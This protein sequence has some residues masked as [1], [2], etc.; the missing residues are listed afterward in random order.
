M[1]QENIVKNKIIIICGP[2]ASSKTALAVECAKRLN[3][4]VISADS[5]YVYK[6][7]NVG[8]AK[9]T[10]DEMQGVVHHLIDVIDAD[11]T[12]SVG[13]YK[14]LAEQAINN[15]ISQGKIPIICGGTGFYINSILFDLSY[16][17][18]VANLSAREHY[19]KLAD[20][21]GN[22][23][24]HNILKEKDPVS[25]SKIHFNDTKRVIRALEIFESGCIKSAINDDLTPKYD[26]KA[27]CVNYPREVLYDRIN[28]RVD[29]MFNNGLIEEIEGLR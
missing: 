20:E 26:Y 19:K 5:L 29:N 16:G 8:T 21:F 17:N 11:Q 12:F 18:S 15:I 14:I 3:S 13:D 10:L 4:Q 7:L 1:V 23:Y 25:A 28:K 6:N 22:Q 2:T 27:Y 9:P 24:V